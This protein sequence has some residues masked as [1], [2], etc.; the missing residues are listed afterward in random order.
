MITFN[1]FRENLELTLDHAQPIEEG[2]LG[3]IGH[4]LKKVAVSGLF[5]RRSAITKMIHRNMDAKRR[6]RMQSGYGDHH[7]ARSVPRDEP[8]ATNFYNPSAGAPDYSK[9]DKPTYLRRGGKQASLPSTRTPVAK[10]VELKPEPTPPRVAKKVTTKRTTPTPKLK[11][12][13]SLSRVAKKVTAKRVVA[14]RSAKTKQQ[15]QQPKVVKP[16]VVKPVK[17]Q[18][19]MNREAAKKYRSFAENY[20]S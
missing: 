10:P 7:T 13:P 5:G 8:R 15:P 6:A 1:Q 11:S 19:D 17:T 16:K 18:H 2:I 9:F 20:Y 14:V 4:H 3:D 12:T